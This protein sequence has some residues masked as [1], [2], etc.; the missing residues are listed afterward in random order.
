[1]SI[2]KLAGS[3]LLF[4]LISD[5]QALLTFQVSSLFEG[6]YLPLLKEKPVGKKLGEDSSTTTPTSLTVTDGI[7][8]CEFS[9]AFIAQAVSVALADYYLNPSIDKSNSIS[10]S[11]KIE[12]VI[13]EEIE[14]LRLNQ[15]KY[16]CP[17]INQNER[18][19]LKHV[20]DQMTASSTTVITAELQSSEY[21]SHGTLNIYQKGDS[22]LAIF[23]PKP[24]YN[25][26]GIQTGSVYDLVFYTEEQQMKF[27]TPYQFNIFDRKSNPVPN[28]FKQFI[29][30]ENDIVLLGSDG[31]FDNMSWSLITI[32]VNAVMKEYSTK[33][34]SWEEIRN[35]FEE[36]F[37]E[38]KK[39]LRKNESMINQ[40]FDHK[41]WDNEVIAG[42]AK[43]P[44]KSQKDNKM[45]FI[46]GN[47]TKID[48]H[49]R[50][51]TKDLEVRGRST[52][53][54]NMNKQYTS[55]EKEIKVDPIILKATS[56]SKILNKKIIE[57]ANSDEYASFLKRSQTQPENNL[58]RFYFSLPASRES[59][60]PQLNESKKA[61]RNSSS[62]QETYN[63]KLSENSNNK[64]SLHPPLSPSPI[65]RKEG[66]SLSSKVKENLPRNGIE[67]TK[68]RIAV[69]VDKVTDNNCKSH[70]A[71]NELK[72]KKKEDESKVRNLVEKASLDKRPNSP[73]QIRKNLSPKRF[74]TEPS[75]SGY[76]FYFKDKLPENTNAI[77]AVNDPKSST[78]N[79]ENSSIITENRQ[80]GRYK[81]NLLTKKNNFEVSGLNS[82]SDLSFTSQA[83]PHIL[84]EKDDGHKSMISLNI[85]DLANKSFN[86]DVRNQNN[87]FIKASDNSRL[88]N[89]IFG[90]NRNEHELI[91]DSLITTR[92]RILSSQ[93]KTQSL[94][95]SFES[96]NPKYLDSFVPYPETRSNMSMKTSTIQNSHPNLLQNQNNMAS[97]IQFRSNSLG[98]IPTNTVYP[99]QMQFTNASESKIESG[100][101]QA[102]IFFKNI[103][104]NCKAVNFLW[105]NPLP[106]KLYLIHPCLHSA[107]SEQFSISKEQ[108][109]VFTM[110]VKG[111]DVA[112]GLAEVGK[113]ASETKTFYPSPF[114]IRAV[115]STPPISASPLAK[116]DDVTAVVGY[117]KNTQGRSTEVGNKFK[118]QSN[119]FRNE[120]YQGFNESLSYFKHYLFNKIFKDQP[121]KPLI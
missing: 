21:H 19:H 120:I 117:I 110:N 104:Q 121:M 93:S 96:W 30:Y 16:F 42:F 14:K 71:S 102:K 65:I 89:R 91:V 81:F 24:I 28:E 52:E 61:D 23:R 83:R 49:N 113:I 51:S 35:L 3:I 94:N 34:L 9:S 106:E 62:F 84:A 87:S 80:S 44:D 20:T 13:L 54:A 76:Q 78:G 31:L 111:K 99:Q 100:N 2:T 11:S 29:V 69:P 36:Y 72:E 112:R 67:I 4:F 46:H 38:Y 74:E 17:N 70:S 40:Y 86:S 47:D 63:G 57:T 55:I 41:E 12:S 118:E 26:A 108:F 88:R 10:F 33:A 90:P 27:N 15:G 103:L 59:A 22:L 56:D 109:R 79:T 114:Y 8:G 37:K 53:A 58:N 75:S 39:I 97:T 1:M 85:K 82:D 107:I 48:I 105:E 66:I 101:K 119:Q 18:E 73:G 60:T 98:N 116:K 5:L 32:L 115:K 7:G 68:S 25:L 50:L 77:K 45:S 6:G 92:G 43:Y 64:A 95:N